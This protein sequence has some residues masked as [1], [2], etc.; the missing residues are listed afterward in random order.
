MRQLRAEKT[1]KQVER[2]S[3]RGVPAGAVIG[4]PKPAIDRVRKQYDRDQALAQALWALEVHEAR[5]IAVNLAEPA[6]FTMATAKRWIADIWSW[7]L[8][9][10]FARYL[11]LELKQRD[12]LIDRH[13]TSLSLYEKRVGFAA[14]ACSAIHDDK[15][16][17]ETLWHWLELIQQAAHDDR[18]HVRQAV[19]WALREIGKLDEA[20]QLRAIDCANELLEGDKAQQWVA[21]TAL[22]ELENLV[23]V[24]ERRRLIRST[25]K[26]GSKC[27]S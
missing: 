6:R 3:A 2:V 22:R 23:R 26:T 10:H 4:V 13:V 7:D 12:Q 19:E 27:S 14:I 25:S 16:K 1:D 21:R 11:L 15:L 24:K 9:D 8:C 5:L 18:R 20:W 17:E